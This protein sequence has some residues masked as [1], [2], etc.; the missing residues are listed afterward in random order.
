MSK[1]KTTT[2]TNYRDAGNGRYV[3]ETYAKKH[4]GTTV[5]ET[6]KVTTKKGK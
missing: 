3:T 6:D 2:K 1:A 4:P 5:K